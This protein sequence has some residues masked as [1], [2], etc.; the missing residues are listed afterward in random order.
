MIEGYDAIA[1]RAA[2]TFGMFQQSIAGERAIH[3]AAGLDQA[4]ARKV[5]HAAT[6]QRSTVNGVIGD[7]WQYLMNLAAGGPDAQ[8]MVRDTWMVAELTAQ[9][10]SISS[11]IVASS[12]RAANGMSVAGMINAHGSM[13][14]LVQRRMGVSDT[15]VK[16]AAGRLW[17]AS[18][19]VQ[20]LVRDVAFRAWVD[21]RTQDLAGEGTPGFKLVHANGEVLAQALFSDP[22]WRDQIDAAIHFNSTLTVEAWDGSVSS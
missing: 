14:L 16:D 13:G 9:L 19:L 22:T 5:S 11:Q 6:M 1:Q 2:S 18:R 12:N 20:V 17:D 3:K 4:M 8:N 10:A 7:L 15:K 21:A